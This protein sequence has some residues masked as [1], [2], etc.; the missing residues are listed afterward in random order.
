MQLVEEEAVA[1]E[2]LDLVLDGG[3]GDRELAGDLA[4]CG[5]GQGPEEQG[6]EEVGSFEP[7]GDVKG[8]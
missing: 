4:V 2:T 3:G 6:G 8:L 5:A 1:S 7:V